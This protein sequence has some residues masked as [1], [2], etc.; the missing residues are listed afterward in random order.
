MAF[1]DE[2]L[3]RLETDPASGAEYP[4]GVVRAYRK[5]LNMIR[6][7]PDERIFRL[8]KGLRYEKL[9]GNRSGQHSMRLN[10]QFRLILRI[11]GD[12]AAKTV[13]I[14]AIEDYH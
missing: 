9:K 3:D 2:D 8:S 12:T 7:A 13:V 5:C 11:E 14:M 10:S 6:S 4:P 1:D